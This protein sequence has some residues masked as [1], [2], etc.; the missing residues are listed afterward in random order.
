[1]ATPWAASPVA[2]PV[3]SAVAEPATPNGRVPAG[4]S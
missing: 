1:L 2:S 4:S 3:A